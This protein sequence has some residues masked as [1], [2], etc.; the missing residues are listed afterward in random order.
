[1]NALN[2]TISRVDSQTVNSRMWP[3]TEKTRQLMFKAKGGDQSA[4]NQL[5]DRHRNS[6]DHLVRMRLDKKLSLIHI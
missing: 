1:M 5:L 6:L 2:S 4:V 3:E